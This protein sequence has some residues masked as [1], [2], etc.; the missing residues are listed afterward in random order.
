MPIMRRLR[1]WPLFLTLFLLACQKDPPVAPTTG[2]SVEENEILAGTIVLADGTPVGDALVRFYT[3]DFLPARTIGSPKAARTEDLAFTTRTDAKGH[4]HVDSL[5][6]GEYNILAGNAAG[7]ASFRDSVFLIQGIRIEVSDTLR[8]PSSLR[9]VVAL[10]PNHD[11][12][13][14]TVQVLGTNAFTNVDSAGRF[15]LQGLAAGQYTLRASTT[16]DQYTPLFTGAKVGVGTADSLQDTLRLTY[17]GIPVVTG[18]RVVFDT[19]AGLAMVSWN[20]VHYR[21]FKSFVVLRGKRDPL[22]PLDTVIGVTADTF[23]VDTVFRPGSNDYGLAS[24]KFPDPT[25]VEYLVKVRNQSRNDGESYGSA[26]FNVVPPSWAQTYTELKLVGAIGGKASLNDTIKVVASFRNKTRTFRKI[27]WRI[28]G[29]D[30]PVRDLELE[31]GSHIGTDTLMVT[32]SQAGLRKVYC[33]VVDDAEKMW[34]TIGDIDFIRVAP[35]AIPGPDTSVY[36]GAKVKLHGKG[37]TQFGTIVKWEWDVG[38]KGIFQPSPDGSFEFTAP[39][40]LGIVP[41]ALRVTNDDGETNTGIVSVNVNRVW[42]KVASVLPFMGNDG[43]MVYWKNRVW[44]IGGLAGGPGKGSFFSSED[45]ENW[46][47]E[48]EVPGITDRQHL[49]AIVFQD[50][51]FVMGGQSRVTGESFSDIWTTQDGVSWSKV[52][53]SLNHSDYGFGLIGGSVPPKV[54]EFKQRMWLFPS[55]IYY[56][57]N[58]NYIWSSSDGRNWVVEELRG[59][60]DDNDNRKYA[61]EVFD[62]HLVAVG[63]SNAFWSSTDGLHW[64]YQFEY[65]KVSKYNPSLKVFDGKLWVIGGQGGEYTTAYTETSLSNWQDGP[66]FPE[67]VGAGNVSFLL[68]NTIWV[69]YDGKLWKLR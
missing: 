42:D 52:E 47:E 34:T 50:Q 2:G 21:D 15:T 10:Q 25:G 49:A 3:V 27:L 30:D 67:P 48:P 32:S 6:K 66:S 39:D 64:S 60:M 37:T 65:A 5:A 63:G 41:C 20:K 46:K 40:E 28:S 13:T 31:K 55:R 14:A 38:L 4:Y 62:N 17:T 23:W 56:N 11:P 29:Q 16:L 24:G 33:Q 1:I 36:R 69:V 22:V 19:L 8:D 59:P 43:K 54:V 35:T 61:V 7:Q 26:A 44:M 12:R 9:G 68:Q 57:G 58:I 45:G 18:F 53:I 51:L